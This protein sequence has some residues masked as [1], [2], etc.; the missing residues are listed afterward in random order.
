[1]AISF[2]RNVTGHQIDVHFVYEGVFFHSACK[3]IFNAF[4]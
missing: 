1:M 2:L 3:D 4:G